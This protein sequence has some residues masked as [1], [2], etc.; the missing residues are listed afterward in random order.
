MFR[1]SRERFPDKAA[2]V[3]GARRM[4]YRELDAAA[5]RLAHALRAT[6]A[7]KGAKVAILSRNLLE[8]GVVFF[9]AARSGLVL[10]NVSIQYAAAELEYVL[11]KSDAEILLVDG[12]FAEKA[13]AVLPQCPGDPHGR[14]HWRRR[15]CR[16]QAASP[17][18]RFSLR[19]AARRAAGRASSR[20]TP[21][22]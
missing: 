5:N 15:L 12:Q 8:Y 16:F 13:A 22:A 2:I 14:L 21:S 3:A 20:P 18:T 4:S 10:V 19:P 9:G 1:R 11:D 6:G 17:S 7:A